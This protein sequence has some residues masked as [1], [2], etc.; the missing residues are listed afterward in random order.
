MKHQIIY[1]D[2]EAEQTI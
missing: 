1:V 2:K